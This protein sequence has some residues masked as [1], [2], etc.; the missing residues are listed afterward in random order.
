MR[1]GKAIPL[2]RTEYSLLQCLLCAAGKVVQ[3]EI[4]IA[5]VWGAGHSVSD[6][7]LDAFVRLLRHKV[8]GEGRP[9]LIHTVRGVGYMVRVESPQ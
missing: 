9:K 2:T 4:L 8:E 1:D 6:N 5:S 7:S 3:R